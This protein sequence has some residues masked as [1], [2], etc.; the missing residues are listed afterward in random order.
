[1]EQSDPILNMPVDV[2]SSCGADG[3]LRPYRLRLEEDHALQVFSVLQ[4]LSDKEIKPAGQPMISYIC[5]IGSQEQSRLAELRY[6]ISRQRW[7]LYRLL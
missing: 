7:C 1:M 2:I 6:H 3:R 5:R 4:I